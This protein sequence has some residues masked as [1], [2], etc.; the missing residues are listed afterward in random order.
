[1]SKIYNLDENVKHIQSQSSFN[2]W[3]FLVTYFSNCTKFSVITFDI[4]D[5]PND[6]DVIIYAFSILWY[7]QE[8][9]ENIENIGKK[10]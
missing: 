6:V 9:I 7:V 10:I 4:T 2:R 1:M 5:M 8:K 3:N